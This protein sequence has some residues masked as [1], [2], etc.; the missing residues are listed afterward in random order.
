MKRAVGRKMIVERPSSV[1][2]SCG[3]GMDYESSVLSISGAS[4]VPVRW[5]EAD[6]GAA[7]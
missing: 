2:V 5:L 6:G 7:L 1:V 3:F 4:Y